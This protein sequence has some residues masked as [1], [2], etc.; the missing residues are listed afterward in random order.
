MTTAQAATSPTVEL[1]SFVSKGSG[2]AASEALRRY[3]R[4]ASVQDDR[5]G[6]L[7]VLYRIAHDLSC[8][9]EGTPSREAALAVCR[10]MIAIDPENVP[11]YGLAAQTLGLLR[12]HEEACAY[13]AEIVRR[14]PTN[15]RAHS[16]H[17]LMLESGGRPAEAKQELYKAA[18]LF[19]DNE[20]PA[21][22]LQ[23]I[24]LLDELCPDDKATQE[25][26][27]AARAM[28]QRT[29]RAR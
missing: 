17:A 19:M 8:V 12:R 7:P 6:T 27:R 22:A 3:L 24:S 28:Q 26:R 2:T 11:A 4:Q 15:P 20:M 13:T 16:T 29:K 1:L 23:A 21:D 14:E 9:A 10:R 5:V 18:Q 25:L